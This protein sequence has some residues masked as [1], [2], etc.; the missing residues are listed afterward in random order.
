[1]K[2]STIVRGGIGARGISNG[3]ESG[4]EGSQTDARGR[5]LEP[6]RERS[7]AFSSVDNRQ[8]LVATI[9][10]GVERRENPSVERRSRSRQR[11]ISEFEAERLRVEVA[12]GQT[13]VAR[14]EFQL[15][16]LGWDWNLGWATCN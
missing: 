4:R 16:Q 14:G 15:K 9:S 6:E 5:E 13:L 1:M 3:G 2:Q 11:R 12:N 7:V 10:C 8:R